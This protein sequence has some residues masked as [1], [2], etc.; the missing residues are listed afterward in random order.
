MC[1]CGFITTGD[2]ALRP[3]VNTNYPALLL[4]CVFLSPPQRKSNPD[5]LL[6]PPSC[7]STCSRLVQVTQF[8]L[9]FCRCCWTANAAGLEKGGEGVDRREGHNRLHHTPPGKHGCWYD[10]PARLPTKT[11][12][13]LFSLC[14]KMTR[15]FVLQLEPCCNS[16]G[17]CINSN[18][19]VCNFP[20]PSIIKSSQTTPIFRALF[21]HLGLASG[22]SV[23]SLQQEC[24]VPQEAKKQLGFTLLLELMLCL[25]LPCLEGD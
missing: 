21:F 20:L 6:R 24:K 5:L 16:S 11:P 4:C 19:W 15:L 3:N 12:N 17:W 25:Y 14:V 1:Y 8:A 23:Y 18:L 10:N 22:S 9:P 2:G 7:D 13:S